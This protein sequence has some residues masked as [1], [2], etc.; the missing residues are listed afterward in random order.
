MPDV[1]FYPLIKGKSS[2]NNSC[3]PIYLCSKFK[4]ANFAVIEKIF[5]L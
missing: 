3:C 4:S 2:Q 5:H 1:W